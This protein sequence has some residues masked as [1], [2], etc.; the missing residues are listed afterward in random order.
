VSTT[1]GMITIGFLVRHWLVT[2]F[3]PAAV[4]AIQILLGA[5]CYLILL[6]LIWPHFLPTLISDVSPRALQA[7]RRFPLLSV[8]LIGRSSGRSSTWTA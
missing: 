3:P 5:A 8:L 7:L 6:R 1:I 2:I 4:V